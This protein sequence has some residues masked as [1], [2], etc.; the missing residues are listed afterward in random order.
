MMFGLEREFAVA[1]V[2]CPADNICPSGV[3]VADVAAIVLK[4]SLLSILVFIS[5]PPLSPI[6][7]I[8]DGFVA[9]G[10]R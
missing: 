3:K 10:P 9:P 2:F 7:T 4:N 5:M 1:A 8:T 6:T